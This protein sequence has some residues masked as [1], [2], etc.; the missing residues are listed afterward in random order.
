VSDLVHRQIIG[1]GSGRWWVRDD[2][3]AL[4]VWCEHGRP[5]IQRAPVNEWHDPRHPHQRW[6]GTVDPRRITIALDA[7]GLDGPEVDEALGV[8]NALDTVVDSWEAGDTAPTLSEL[9]RLCTL[10]GKILAWFFG[11]TPLSPTS[12]WACGNGPCER[13]ES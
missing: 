13:I 12:G 6:A 2:A 8:H 10:T 9:R 1:P 4:W 7:L 5:W 3:G 11:A